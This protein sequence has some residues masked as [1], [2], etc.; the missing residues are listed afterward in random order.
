[1]PTFEHVLTERLD[2]RR[3]DPVADLAALFSVFTDPDGWWYDP[4]GRH[5]DEDT[6]RGWLERAAARFDRDGLSYWTVRRR[7]TAEIIGVGGAQRQST[8][9]WNLNYRIASDQQG[10]GFATELARAAQSAASSLDPDVPF[11][12]W[13]AA[14]NEPSRKVAERLGLTN[15]GP[16]VDP[17][18]GRQRIAYADRPFA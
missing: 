13:I 17:S 10:K 6:T 8:G 14:N 15:H 9:A 2:L 16:G 12:A 1:M 4:A 7:D 11:I 5:R 18:D 3:P